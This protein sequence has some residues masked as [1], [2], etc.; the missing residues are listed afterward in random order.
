MAY[1]SCTRLE[2]SSGTHIKQLKAGLTPS[3]GHLMSVTPIVTYMAHVHIDT[4]I[5]KN[6]F[7]KITTK[8]KK[9]IWA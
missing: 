3:P 9:I 2:F 7:K 6:K 1:R 5:V 4:H 8:Q